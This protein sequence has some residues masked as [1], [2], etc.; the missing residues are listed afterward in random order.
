M[1]IK[2]EKDCNLIFRHIL[3]WPVGKMYTVEEVSHQ[4]GLSVTEVEICH[5][6][7][8]REGMARQG[9]G[10]FLINDVCREFA[11]RGGYKDENNEVSVINFIGT[12][13]GTANQG[14]DLRDIATKNK[15]TRHP[16]KNDDNINPKSWYEIPFVKYVLLPLLIAA[17]GVVL[18]IILTEK[19]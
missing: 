5:S 16:K 7:L 15:V 12:N 18:S 1:L 10:Y 19:N 3:N 17:A 9:K 8:Y 4:T 13:Y 11:E 6:K 14:S 2:V